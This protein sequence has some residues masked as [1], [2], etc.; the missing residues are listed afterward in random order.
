MVWQFLATLLRMAYHIIV[1]VDVKK[2][3]DDFKEIFGLTLYFTVQISYFFILLSLKVIYFD[4]VM[5]LFK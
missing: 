2:L 3:S 4:V 5:M 1:D